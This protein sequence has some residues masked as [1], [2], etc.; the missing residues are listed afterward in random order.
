M[1]SS[2]GDGSSVASIHGVTNRRISQELLMTRGLEKSVGKTPRQDKVRTW[3]ES[4]IHRHHFNHR[5]SCWCTCMHNTPLHTSSTSSSSDRVLLGDRQATGHTAPTT[6]TWQPMISR[7]CCRIQCAIMPS[8]SAW[9]SWKG[10]TLLVF[11]IDQLL[12]SLADW[13]ML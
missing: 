10:L 2:Y 1:A 4:Y 11:I 6:K 5:S 3:V 9:G 7:C 8:E 12:F 13:L